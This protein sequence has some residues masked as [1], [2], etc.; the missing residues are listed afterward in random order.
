MGISK[1]TSLVSITFLEAI[2]RLHHDAGYNSRII[3]NKKVSPQNYNKLLRQDW[4]QINLSLQVS[5][6][7]NP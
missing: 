6:L 1:S 3:V 7:R 4:L 5:S 2:N